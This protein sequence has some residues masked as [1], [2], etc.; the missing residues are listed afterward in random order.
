MK[1]MTVSG[2]CGLVL[3]LAQGYSADQEYLFVPA[4]GTPFG[5]GPFGWGYPG[6]QAQVVLDVHGRINPV[7]YAAR[8]RSE[9]TRSGDDFNKGLLPLYEHNRANETVFEFRSGRLIQGRW[10][11]S[12]GFAPDIGKR[13][14]LLSEFMKSKEFTPRS[15]LATVLFDFEGSYGPLC[16]G[17]PVIYNL[18]G[19][20]VRRNERH[21]TATVE[22]PQLPKTEV[23][24]AQ[25]NAGPTDAGRFSFQQDTGQLHTLRMGENYYYG[26]VSLPS[27]TFAPKD[28][29]NP[30]Q[31]EDVPG[32]KLPEL[33]KP[34]RKNEPVYEIRNGALIPGF[35]IEQKDDTLFVPE[36]GA[37]VMNAANYL[38]TY[39]PTSRR[40]YNLPGKFVE[41]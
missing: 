15:S 14:I 40:V 11:E 21:S 27:G 29:L 9:T 3:F 30:L 32:Y 36:E 7:E 35:L 37:E 8:A 6:W 4:S 5:W 26:H 16:P 17:E 22:Y 24:A 13:V 39:S 34:H 12:N 33:M 19:C 2:L 41:R 1:R 28:L 20:F 23:R 18:P 25:T 31:P 38:K 10:A